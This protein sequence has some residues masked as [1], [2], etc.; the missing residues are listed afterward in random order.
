MNTPYKTIPYKG[1]SVEIHID[2]EPMDPRK[3][4]DN[5]GTMVCCHKRYDL[6][7]KHNYKHSDYSSWKEFIVA[8]EKNEGPIV[9][10]PIYMYDHSGITIN[11]TGYSHCDSAR[12]DW[13]QLGFIYITKEKIRKEYGWKVITAKRLEQ[14][15]QYLLSEV[16]IYD[17]YLT[18]EVYGYAIKDPTG[19]ELHSCWGYFGYD[20]EKSGLMEAA[21][22]EIDYHIN[23]P[24]TK[25]A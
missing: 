20:H 18:G 8:V 6:G 24:V 16:E 19:E 23:N 10:L 7:D 15:K 12:W 25:V 21:K 13:D 9:W 14:I 11:T 2:P 17:Q 4:F 5:L 1:C 22:N 3:E